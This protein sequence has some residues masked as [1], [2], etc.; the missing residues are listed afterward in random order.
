MDDHWPL[1]QQWT[2]YQHFS[3]CVNTNQTNP[4]IPFVAGI[5]LYLIRLCPD[6]VVSLLLIV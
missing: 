1:R 3:R 4:V 2:N 6:A 5:R